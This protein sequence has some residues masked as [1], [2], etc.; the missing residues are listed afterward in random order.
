LEVLECAFL[1]DLVGTT[2]VGTLSQ[3]GAATCHLQFRHEGLSPQLEC[4]QNCRAGW[5]HYLPSLRDYIQ[6][7]KGIPARWPA[8][9]N[10]TVVMAAST[11]Q[12]DLHVTDRRR[13]TAGFTTD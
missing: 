9:G 12:P 11:D 7:G 4:D 2:P 3:D 10:P 13:H 6:T 5:E 1:P 8:W